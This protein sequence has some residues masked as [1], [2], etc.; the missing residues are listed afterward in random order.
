MTVVDFTTAMATDPSSRA[1]SS[2]ASELINET[3]R[4]GPHCIST[5]AITVSRLMS[6]TSPTKRLRAERPTPLGSST[7]C[8]WSRASSATW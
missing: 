7:A 5:W 2:T 3:T 8:A 6:V 1:R 4:N